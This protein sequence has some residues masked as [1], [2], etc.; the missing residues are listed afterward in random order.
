MGVNYKALE[1]K[2]RRIV[3]KRIDEGWNVSTGE[4]VGEGQCCLIGSMAVDIPGYLEGYSNTSGWD[5]AKK[6]LGVN[7]YILMHG[8]ESTGTHA[9]D[10]LYAVGANLRRIYCDDNGQVE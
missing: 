4:F 9:D 10:P 7:P 8:F 1:L 6:T 3:E 5:Y 2:L